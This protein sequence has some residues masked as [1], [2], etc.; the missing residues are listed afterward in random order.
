MDEILKAGRPKK[1]QPKDTKKI[2]V[3]I[4][5]HCHKLMMDYQAQTGIM[6]SW[7]M[8]R[9]LEGYFQ[10]L[11]RYPLSKDELKDSNV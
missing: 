1:F 10:K 7:M 2:T 4:P 11:G 6:Q 8:A 5:L 3:D 9:A